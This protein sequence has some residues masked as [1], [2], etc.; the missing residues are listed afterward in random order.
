MARGKALSNRYLVVLNPESNPRS[1]AA[2]AGVQ[3]TYLYESALNGFA[4]ELNAGQLNA[5]RHNPNVAYVEQDQV[6][7]VAATQDM[8]ETGDPWGLDRI[9]QRALPLS[10]TFSYNAT[11][12][13][14]TAYII[15]T[16]ILTTHW[17]FDGR[18]ANVYDTD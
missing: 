15:D 12:K 8:D 4:A 5:L 11:G 3:P 10:Q 2:I 17:D 16:G 13:G 14:V 9:D 18:A 7:S 6:V 1:V